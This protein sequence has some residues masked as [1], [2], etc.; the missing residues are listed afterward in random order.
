MKITKSQQESV[1]LFEKFA[2][3][4]AMMLPKKTQPFF[5][6]LLLGALLAI[7]RRRTVT[8]WL[9]AAQ[10]SDD[11][12]QAFYH[13]PNIGC[14][15]D[16]IFSAMTKIII[17]QLGPVIATAAKIRL[18]LDDSPTKRYGRKIE[19]A[20]YHHNPTPGRTNAKICFGHSWVVAVLVVTH[21]T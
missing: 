16:E 4:L 12:R 7:A 9:M 8:Q 19:G 11:Y 2:E 18:V 14:K 3:R 21:P 10:I 15:G 1:S 5:I 13:I 20:G 17:E 6:S